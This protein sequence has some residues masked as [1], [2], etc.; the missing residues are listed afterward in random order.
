M[1]AFQLSASRGS[2]IGPMIIETQD[3]E[4]DCKLTPI[5]IV[6]NFIDL[7]MTFEGDT[8][9]IVEKDTVFQRLIEDGFRRHFPNI[10][11]VTVCVLHFDCLIYKHV[12]G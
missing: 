6:Q 5:S 8:V 12:L 9:L 3:G 7:N 2:L 4:V 1:F 11:L 10:L